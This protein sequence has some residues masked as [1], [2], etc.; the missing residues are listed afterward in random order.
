MTNIRFHSQSCIFHVISLNVKQGAAQ[1]I[2]QYKNLVAI[3]RKINR[4]DM[5]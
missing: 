2:D 5:R 1:F 3:L 4:Y